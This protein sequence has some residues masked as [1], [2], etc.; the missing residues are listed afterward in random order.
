MLLSFLSALVGGLFTLVGVYFSHKVEVE[1]RNNRDS[2]ELHGFLQG[3]SRDIECLW[4]IYFSS[5]GQSLESLSNEQPAEFTYVADQDYLAYFHGNISF[6]SKV[7]NLE[8]SMS[9][10][11]AYLRV[12]SLLDSWKINT[13]LVRKYE[14]ANAIMLQNPTSQKKQ[15]CELIYKELVEYCSVLNIVH[16]ECKLDIEELRKELKKSG[17]Q[18]NWLEPKPFYNKWSKSLYSLLIVLLCLVLVA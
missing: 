8:L 10:N 2:K 7:D 18:D 16:N 9:I 15:H 4:H 5:V 17:A 12:K 11:I 1:K 3:V 13:N 6:L 14:E